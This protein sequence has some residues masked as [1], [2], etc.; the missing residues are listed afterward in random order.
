MGRREDGG[1]QERKGGDADWTRSASDTTGERKASKEVEA[2]N[3]R[4]FVTYRS[5]S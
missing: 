5:N 4:W 2:S 3:N 1:R